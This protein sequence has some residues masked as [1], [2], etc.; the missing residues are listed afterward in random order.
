M[1]RANPRR[2]GEEG[3][4]ES[5]TVRKIIFARN[6]RRRRGGEGMS[7]EYGRYGYVIRNYI[8]FCEYVNYTG[9]MLSWNIKYC[10]KAVNINKTV[11]LNLS[12][13]CQHCQ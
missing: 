10:V 1:G 7:L 4:E 8:R 13:S 12:G 3:E 9:N 2:V 5:G 6:G 11:V